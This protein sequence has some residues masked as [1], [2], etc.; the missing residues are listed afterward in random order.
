[1][2]SFSPPCGKSQGPLLGA[3]RGS[4]RRASRRSRRP[5]RNHALPLSRSGHTGIGPARCP[6][7]AKEI[8]EKLYFTP[9]VEH[10][11]SVA[12]VSW[13]DDG[14]HPIRIAFHAGGRGNF[15]GAA[16]NSLYTVGYNFDESN[17]ATNSIFHPGWVDATESNFH[18]G[19]PG[20]NSQNNT[21][22]RYTSF[23]R[24]ETTFGVDN[25]SGTAFAQG[26][27]IKVSKGATG[28]IVANG[29]VESFSAGVLKVRWVDHATWN[30]RWSPVFPARSAALAGVSRWV[31]GCARL[32]S[33]AKW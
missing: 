8:P 14:E 10:A 28:A 1:M 7:I 25:T 16:R 17:T 4:H 9:A 31:G 21:W 32:L 23:Q 33:E 20:G 24:A 12:S 5:A 3:P 11:G 27:P 26:Q 6:G 15:S 13:I 19:G 22:E 18:A 2:R 30:D 29:T